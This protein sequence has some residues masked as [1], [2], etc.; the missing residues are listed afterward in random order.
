MTCKKISALLL[1]LAVATGCQ[2]GEM[3][4]L[5]E[6]KTEEAA[7]SVER[8]K[9]PAPPIQHKALTVT[10][11]VWGGSNSLRMRRGQPLPPRFETP[12]AVTLIAAEPMMLSEILNT[13]S[14]QT[15]IAMRLGAGA[16]GAGGMG[17]PASGASTTA[18]MQVSYEGPLSGLLEQVANFYD[19][20]WRFDG[21]SVSFTRYE[22]RMFVV[23]ALPGRMKVSDKISG[24]SSGGSGGSSGSSGGGSG[25]ESNALEQE[26]ETE[27]DLDFWPE[28]TAGVNGLLNGVGNAVVS[29]SA[30]TIMVTTSSEIMKTVA[31]FIEQQNDLLVKQIAIN[32]EVYTVDLNNSDNYS[33][34]MNAVLKKVADS[35][36]NITGATPFSVTSGGT[37]AV[38]ILDNGIATAST[39]VN[40]LSSVGNNVRVAQF[41][42]T[43]LNNRPVSRRIGR[44]RTYLASATTE[45]SQSFQSTTL[46]PGTIREGFSLQLTPRILADGRMLLQYSLNLIDIVQIREITSN[47][48]TVQ[49]P[50]TTNRV[51]V[52]QSLLKSGSTLILA[53]FNQDQNTQNSR[54]IGDAFNYLLGGGV[55][56]SE[57]RQM[58]FIAI[59]PQEIDIPRAE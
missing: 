11:E 32:V 37:F 43:T 20:N 3:R 45:T 25:S 19:L 39:V 42:M 57:V 10:D 35:S 29:Q 2:T 26:N 23:E 16:G 33:M 21:A 36:L 53:G 28:I 52:Q 14:A 46:T 27:A 17:S 44:D 7:Q 47:S 56:N 38:T 40:A 8:A 30:G 15:G 41:P 22:T 49:L 54:G 9:N 6:S 58:L 13:M 1:V 4:D 34:S 5:I 24:E 55:Q 50:E 31:N 12:R 48:N 51:F 18:P 59:T